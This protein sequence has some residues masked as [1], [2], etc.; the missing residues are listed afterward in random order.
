MK[1]LRICLVSLTVSPDS[2][3]GEAKVIR[4][5]FDYLV[6]QGHQVKLI[7]GKWNIDIQNKDI[8]Q[9]KLIRKRFLW[10]PHFI[11]KVLKYLRNNKFDII[12][13]NSA[14]AAFPIILAK[15]KRFITTIHDF[16][17][18]ETKLTS[19]PIEK[20]LIRYV[21]KK[22]TYITTV[23]NYIRQKFR[24]Y[25]PN[26]DIDKVFTIYN[27]IENRFKPNTTESAA[28][29]I[30]MNIIGPV[31]LYVGRITTYKGVDHI[32]EAYKSAKKEISNL[33]LII[34]GKPDYLMEKIYE[35]WKTKYKDIRF[36][37]YIAED[38]V[39][40]F[41][42]MADIFLTYSQ[43]SE[44]FGLTPLEALSCGTPVI[45]S[46]IPVYKEILQ[47]S[48][49]FVPPKNP[50]LLAGKISLLLNDKALR[51]RILKN[52]QKLVQKYSWDK[53]GDKLESIYE[54]FV[55]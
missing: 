35:S 24:I 29:K 7:T 36:V 13:A 54:K 31:L 8:I 55:A 16:T 14:K 49:L 40:I 38:E 52:A 4:A 30:K 28:L 32:I 18:F 42:S 33:N 19:F 23:S 10:T 51:E 45:C 12:H 34:G 9:F 47:N 43:S 41:Y 37:G 53:V 17:P 26:L 44:G 27:G 2:A 1:K 48:A 3:D 46:S 11:L 22:S 15:K 50:Q 25:V 20:L 6:D 21:A 5:L 39:P